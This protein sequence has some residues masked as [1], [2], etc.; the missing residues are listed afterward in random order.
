M[1]E[2][3]SIDADVTPELALAAIDFSKTKRQV[4]ILS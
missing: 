4:N 3:G 2:I 1:A